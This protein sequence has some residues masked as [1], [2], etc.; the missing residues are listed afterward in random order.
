MWW[1]KLKDKEESYTVVEDSRHKLC[2]NSL[3][4][5]SLNI[6]ALD[7]I[8][9]IFSIFLEVVLLDLLR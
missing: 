1:E 3:E 9:C 6:F 4:E 5:K 8:S 2:W 7:P